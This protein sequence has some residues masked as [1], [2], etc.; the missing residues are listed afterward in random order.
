MVTRY[1]L[2]PLLAFFAIDN[3]F[4]NKESKIT[5]EKIHITSFFILL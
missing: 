5:M 1:S 2:S 4:Q 3:D